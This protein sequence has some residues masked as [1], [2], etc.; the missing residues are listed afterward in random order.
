VQV[1]AALRLQAYF[2]K[3]RAARLAAERAQAD[4]ASLRAARRAREERE[5]AE[6]RERQRVLQLQ[7]QERQRELWR[8]KKARAQ[9]LMA[10]LAV[11]RVGVC[12][13]RAAP[14][15]RVACCSFYLVV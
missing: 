5:A 14:S 13:C 6:L 12:V 3:R 7:E 4:M 11:R 9:K 1:R 15:V 2:R 8:K 10:V